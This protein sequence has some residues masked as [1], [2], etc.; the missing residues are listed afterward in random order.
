MCPCKWDMQFHFAPQILASVIICVWVIYLCSIYYMKGFTVRL[1]KSRYSGSHRFYPQSPCSNN[2]E[3]A[4]LGQYS[5]K[6][7]P[8]YT[9]TLSLME[10]CVVRLLYTSYEFIFKKSNM[11]LLYNVFKLNG[12]IL[13]CLHTDCLLLQ[14]LLQLV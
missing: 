4:T 12:K 10:F 9:K 7:S 3:P 11:R 2:S 13:L 1:I 5:H 8:M 14:Y 6:P